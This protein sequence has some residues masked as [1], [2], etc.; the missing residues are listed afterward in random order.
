[1]RVAGI[2]VSGKRQTAKLELLRIALVAR[3]SSLLRYIS[4]IEPLIAM[5]S[6]NS[7]EP[8]IL[9]LS[10]P[11][12]AIL[13]LNAPHKKNAMDITVYKQLS[14]MLQVS[15][16]LRPTLHR[17]GVSGSAGWTGCGGSAAPADDRVDEL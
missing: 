13:T 9:D 14:S 5:T 3:R 15:S 7:S 11:G 1:M 12:Y 2:R 17:C 4:S 8:I 6:Y 16:R 10:H